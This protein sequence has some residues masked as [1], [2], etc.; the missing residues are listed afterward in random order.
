MSSA[1]RIGSCSGKSSAEMFTPMVFVAPK[2]RPAM[3][4]GEGLHPFL[5]PWCSSRVSIAKPLASA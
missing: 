5:A 4:S 1:T 3:M 2:M